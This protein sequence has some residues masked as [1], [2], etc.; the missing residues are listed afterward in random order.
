VQRNRRLISIISIQMLAYARKKSCNIMQ[1]VL[2]VLLYA[3]N[4]SKRTLETL[5]QCGLCVSYDAVL[6]AMKV[7]HL[8]RSRR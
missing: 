3:T 5:Y 8:S 4:I 6:K 1:G 7:A 2:S